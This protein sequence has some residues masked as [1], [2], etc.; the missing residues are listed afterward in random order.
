FLAKHAIQGTADSLLPAV[1]AALSNPEVWKADGR[2]FDVFSQV[3]KEQIWNGIVAS[4]IGGVFHSH[5]T[6]VMA[7]H[8][9]VGETF[10]NKEA[11][12]QFLES[13]ELNAGTINALLMGLSAVAKHELTQRQ[14]HRA[15][16]RHLEENDPEAMYAKAF[17]DAK[18]NPPKGWTPEQVE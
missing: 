13:G 1:S 4:S 5:S 15:A 9:A 16:Q 8:K 2:G 3:M 14:Q 18:T 10:N 6:A 12:E 11:I 7:I 17:E